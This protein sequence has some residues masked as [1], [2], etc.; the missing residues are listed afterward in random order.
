MMFISLEEIDRLISE[1][2]PYIDLTSLSLGIV[3]QAGRI[4]YFTR[5]DCVVCGTE[6]VGMIF[7]RLNIFKSMASIWESSS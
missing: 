4:S 7:E 2:V 3:E 5:E 6:E 1:D